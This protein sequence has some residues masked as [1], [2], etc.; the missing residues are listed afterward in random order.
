[1]KLSLKKYFVPHAEND[2]KPHMLRR[3]ILGGILLGA[4]LLELVFVSQIYLVLPGGGYLA[5]VLPNV[6]V[7]L[8]NAE[9]LSVNV[10]APELNINP[11]LEAAANLKA[12]DMA[13]KSYFAHTSP[14]GLSPWHWFKLAGYEYR[15]AGEN[16]AVNFVDSEDVVAAWMNS[17][18]HRK[19]IVNPKFTEIGIGTARGVYKGRDTIF[20]V[21]LFGTPK[22]ILAVTSPVLPEVPEVFEDEPPA[23]EAPT[24]DSNLVGGAEA[25]NE[26]VNELYTE[27]ASLV[28]ESAIAA[29]TMPKEVNPPAEGETNAVIWLYTNPRLIANSFLSIG[30][31]LVLLAVLLKFFHVAYVHSVSLLTGSPRPHVKHPMLIANGSAI[32]LVLATFMLLNYYFTGTSTVVL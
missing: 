11:I 30:L 25:A 7:S 14:E 1:M 17:E 4:L 19:N 32:V 27:T 18:G 21:Q 16:L 13:A 31:G 3:E 24:N 22:P 26:N 10:V 29:A 15:Y 12:Q 8:T 2:H 20:V 9:R 5:S 6:L 28:Q 23:K